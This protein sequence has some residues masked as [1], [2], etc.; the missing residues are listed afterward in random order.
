METEK[1]I[2]KNSENIENSERIPDIKDILMKFDDIVVP[3]RYLPSKIKVPRKFIV[4]R[5]TL[6]IRRSIP[7]MSSEKT[8]YFLV[9]EYVIIDIVNRKLYYKAKSGKT[10]RIPLFEEDLPKNLSSYLRSVDIDI[11]S[12]EFNPE[13][14]IINFKNDVLINMTYL[15]KTFI[16]NIE[17]VNTEKFIASLLFNI[18]DDIALLTK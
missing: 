18:Y 2:N 11:F 12:N 5:V 4:A 14:N 6:N 8:F 15:V 13:P 9:S 16:G 1:T 10:F 3:L 17:F 7:A